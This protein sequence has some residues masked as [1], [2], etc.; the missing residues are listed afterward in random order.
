VEANL[1]YLQWPHLVS[2]EA[3]PEL[4]EF[5]NTPERVMIGAAMPLSDIGREWTDAPDAFREWLT[6]FASPMIRNRATL[7]GNLA[8]ASP[9]GDAAPLLLALDFLVAGDVVKT[10]ALE[11][12]LGNVAVL[13]FLVIIRTFLSWSITVEMEGHWPWQVA[14]KE[15]LQPREQ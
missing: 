13:G 4:R 12:T 8:T 10:I 2:V 9:I 11:P 1:R 3:I 14:P 5:S 6:L 7:G 15:E